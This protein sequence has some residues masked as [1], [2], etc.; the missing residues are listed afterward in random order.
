[1]EEFKP[2]HKKPL[3]FL[4]LRFLKKYCLHSKTWRESQK[5]NS[6]VS[7]NKFKSGF[8]ANCLNAKASEHAN[9]PIA[10]DKLAQPRN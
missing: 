4:N 2:P 9:M 7:A 6:R 10:W 1:L 3:M 8:R 5:F